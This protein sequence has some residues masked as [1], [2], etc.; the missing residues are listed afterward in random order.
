MNTRIFQD[1]IDRKTRTIMEEA[2]KYLPSSPLVNQ[3]MTEYT[4]NVLNVDIS[5]STKHPISISDNRPKIVGEKE[6]S[7]SFVS[8]LPSSSYFSL[9]TFSDTVKVLYPMQMLKEKLSVIKAIQSCRSHGMTAMRES[10]IKAFDELKN[11][12]PNYKKRFYCVTDGKGTDGDCMDIADMM[13]EAGVQL[14]F[15][16]FG[17][18]EDID[19]VLM[20][21]LASVTEA[22]KS[23]YCHFGSVRQLSSF[24]VTQTKTI[25]Y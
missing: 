5:D 13:K 6:G 9:I 12:P 17:E 1:Q 18:G 23:L 8:S 10:M 24:L 4:A 3:I 2:G 16:G 22:G 15:I 20:K 25:T 7:T 14:F 11:A 19:E 21:E